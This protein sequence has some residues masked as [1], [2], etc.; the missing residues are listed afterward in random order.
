MVE[1]MDGPLAL[2]LVL[3]SLSLS[4]IDMEP[5]QMELGFLCLTHGARS[6]KA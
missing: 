2:W 4:I 1:L 6:E 5:V 3:L